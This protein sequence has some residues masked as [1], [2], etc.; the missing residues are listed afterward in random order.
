MAVLAGYDPILIDPRGAFAQDHRFPGVEIFEDYPDEVLPE[1]GLDARTAVLTFS[2]DPKIDD[3][4]IEAAL[5]SECFYLG[6]LGSTRTHAK[7][8]ERLQARGF[9]EAQIA[10][11]HAPIGLNIGAKSPSEIA[12]AALAQ[13]TEVLRRG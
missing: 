4:A 1:Y 12:L 11:I 9:T 3:P 8:V 7:R 10:R 5:T 6:S 13:V 2:H